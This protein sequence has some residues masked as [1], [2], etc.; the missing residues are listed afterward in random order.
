VQPKSYLIHRSLEEVMITLLLYDET[1]KERCIQLR[2]V[3][4]LGM[5]L[6]FDGIRINYLYLTIL[7]K[8]DLLPHLA[9]LPFRLSTS[10]YEQL[11]VIWGFVRTRENL[12]EGP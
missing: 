2:W 10:E 5:N 12:Q 8:T 7:H 3:G 11:L 1:R 6:Q 4:P 9:T